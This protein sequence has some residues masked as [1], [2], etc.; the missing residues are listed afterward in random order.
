MVFIPKILNVIAAGL[1]ILLLLLKWLPK[2]GQE[3]DKLKQIIQEKTIELTKKNEDLNH[4][5]QLLLKNISILNY[6]QKVAQIG[7]FK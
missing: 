7:H 2:E 1:V 6:A 3:K 5:N 4:S